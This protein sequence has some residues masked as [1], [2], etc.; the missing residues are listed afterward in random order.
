MDMPGI[1]PEVVP[2]YLKV[3]L[4]HHPVKQKKRSF[5]LNHQKAMA[6]EV[7]KLIKIGFIREIMYPD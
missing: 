6:E 7:D 1:D 5:I 2:H 4:T 3:D